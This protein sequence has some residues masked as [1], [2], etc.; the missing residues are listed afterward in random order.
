[1][2]QR[3]VRT[4]CVPL[5]VTAV[6]T[7]AASCLSRPVTNASPTTNT[8]FTAVVHNEAID[9]V[10]ILFVIDNSASMGDKQEYLAQAVPDLVT[11]LVTPNCVDPVSGTVY[12]P[13]DAQGNGTCAQGKVEF[14]PVHDMHVG[15]LS[16]SLGTRLSDQYGGGAGII[17]DPTQT[18][19]VNGNTFNN[20]NDDR[21]E[22]LNRSGAAETP[23]AD[24]GTLNYLNWFPASNPKNQ[25]KAP[26]PGAPPISDATQLISDFTGLIQG[27]GNYGCG[28]ESQLESWYRFLV[29]PDPYDSLALDS[30]S[31][32]QW[33]GVDTT[34]LQQR[35]AFLRP[36]S[37][38]AIIDMTDENDSEID[39]R[40]VGG[41]GYLLMAQNFEPPRGTSG[42]A[43]D[44]ND[45]G[46]TD[47]TTCNS[48]QFASSASSDPSCELGPFSA[49]NDWGFNANL[50]HVHMM[51]KYGLSSLQFP[52]QRYQ[53]GL[54]SKTVPDRNGEYPSGAQSYQ[55]LTHLDCTNPL[56]AA[57][58][59]DGSSTD[60]ATLCNLPPGT[61]TPDLI[62]YAHIGGVPHELLQQDPT[63]PDS[64]PKEILADADWK[65]I[66]GNDPLNFDYTGIDPHMIES[67]QPRAG[68]PTPSS[69]GPPATLDADNGYDWVTDQGSQHVLAVDREYAC[70]F[71][72]TTPR[73]CTNPSDPTVKY[74]CDCPPSTGLTP[75]QLPPICNPST[76]TQQ[77]GAKTYP[78]QRELL[79]AKLMG[80]QGFISSLCP[81][82][83]Q[84]AAGRDGRD[85]PALRIQ[86]RRERTRR[87]PQGVPQQPVPAA[88]AHPGHVGQRALSHSRAAGSSGGAGRLREPGQR[89]PER[90]GVARPGGR[91]A[92]RHDGAPDR[93]HPD[94][95]LRCAGAGVRG[96]AGRSGRSGH[97]PDVRAAA[98]DDGRQ[99]F[100][101]RQ[102][103][104]RR[105][106]PARVVLRH[107]RGSWRL[108]ASHPLHE[109]RAAHGSDREPPVHRAVGERP[110][111]RRDRRC[112]HRVRVGSTVARRLYFLGCGISMSQSTTTSLEPPYG[113]KTILSNAWTMQM[114]TGLPS[115]GEGT[116]T[117]L[118][119]P[120]RPRTT[121]AFV[122]P[123]GPVALPSSSVAEAQLAFT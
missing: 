45:D 76:P 2:S 80:Q 37:L 57:S 115:K 18:V 96:H 87:P 42:C 31:H 104:V 85:R 34:I 3:L 5:A 56:F 91:P 64:P 4:L 35:A 17:C 99:P 101:F 119:W 83:V 24:A 120:F 68:I 25:G 110:R 26:S 111:G 11:R 9:K 53:L 39:V 72:L 109:R 22:L 16:T 82:H 15:V 74:A 58:L 66:L 8:N 84:P 71:P 63:S 19:T 94:Q 92:R 61:R 112:R 1:M 60:A 69:S 54:T 29:Q 89:V 73:D 97:V 46:L 50:R 7:A 59:P 113:G 6:S 93:G 27:V 98:A 52:I 38:V 123:Q 41:Q 14:P 116:V 75:Q 121:D 107:G 55:G 88:A 43:E 114:P 21:A 117:C 78:T 28:I 49:Q 10:D 65:A 102:R 100:G 32:A 90:P 36:D 95:V 51:Q 122:D 70:T 79:L 106:E 44:G 77:V 40:A 30:N 67:Y 103:L 81:I 108:S 33:N 12:G 23:L 47:P 13:S 62:Y 86:P 118:T 105:V 20:H 48:C